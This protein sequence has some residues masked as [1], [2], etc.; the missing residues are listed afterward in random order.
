ML[1]FLTFRWL[2]TWSGESSKTEWFALIVTFPGVKSRFFL[3]QNILVIIL[4]KRFCAKSICT[5]LHLKMTRKKTEY[6]T[7]KKKKLLEFSKCEHKKYLIKNIIVVIPIF[8]D[9]IISDKRFWIRWT[10]T[11][12]CASLSNSLLV[13]ILYLLRLP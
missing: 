1:N 10:N 2:N 3:K 12:Y 8:W 9:R 7:I 6:L 5:S 4:E 13:D 11:V